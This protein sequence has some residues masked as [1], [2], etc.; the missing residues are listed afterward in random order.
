M[1][2]ALLHVAPLSWWFR[3]RLS[4]DQIDGVIVPA[5]FRTFDASS[6]AFGAN[7]FNPTPR[8]ADAP[9][10]PRL[11]EVWSERRTFPGSQGHPLA[12]RLDWRSTPIR[13]CAVIVHCFTCGKDLR[14]ANIISRTLAARGVAVLRFDLT[15]IGESEGDFAATNFSSS[16]ADV[17]SAVDYADREIG[18]TK[19]LIGHSLGGTAAILAA[20]Q[21]PQLAGLATIGAPFRADH[22]RGLIAEDVATIAR[23]GSA[24]VSIAGRPFTITGQFLSDLALAEDSGAVGRLGRPLLILH[25][26]A[27][28]IVDIDNAH[29][30]FE[31][32]SH[33]KSLIALDGADHLLTRRDDALFAAE[34]IATWATRLVV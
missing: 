2:H 3:S 33:P 11:I 25:A 30:I 7:T 10:T 28:D 15:G 16:V 34:M 27:D 24:T 26:P 32:A 9:S 23:D 14:A 18:P 6:T 17:V 5:H 19:L 8:T 12:A 13:Q 22:I 1:R 20:S 29:R 4:N 31:A 21:L